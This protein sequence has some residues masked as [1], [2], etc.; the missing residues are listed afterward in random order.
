MENVVKVNFLANCFLAFFLLSTSYLDVVA[1][2]SDSVVM[3]EPYCI[4]LSSDTK[5]EQPLTVGNWRKQHSFSM[6]LL[7][8]NSVPANGSVEFYE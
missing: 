1:E 4:F 8:D 5:R 2:G 7:R 3:T 6:P